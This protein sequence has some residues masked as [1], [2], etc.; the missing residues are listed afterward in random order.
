M[1]RRRRGKKNNTPLIAVLVAAVAIG[2]IV[3]LVSSFSG[4]DSGCGSREEDTERSGYCVT[5]RN[6]YDELVIVTGNTQNTPAPD[7]DFTQGEL[8]NI[9][10]GVFYSAERGS[11]PSVSIVSASG[12]NHTIDYKAKYKVAQNIIASNN[13]LKKLGKELNKAIKSSPLEPGADYLGGIIEASNL[14]SNTAKNPIIIVVGSGYNDSGALN[15]ASSE[16]LNS[17]LQNSDSITSILS[18]NRQTKEGALNGASVYWYNIGDVVSPQSSMNKYKEDT[19]GIYTLALDYLG[20]GR[21]SLNNYTGVTADAKSVPSEYSVQQVYVDELKIGDTFSVNENIGRFYPD[22]DVL[23]EPAE[24]KEKLTSFAKRF[25]PVSD[26]KLKLTGYIAFCVDDGQLGLS[27]AE[28]IKGILI[29]LGVP[30]DKIE[31]HG[32]RGSPPESPNE[33]Y[34]C[35]S[36]LPETERRTVQIEVVKG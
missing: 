2:A 17:Y 18:Q 19:R 9:L 6:D 3:Y 34:T 33:S 21:I 23:I 27:R 24:V 16:I 29:E 25:N 36:N 31:T 15:F 22:R 10:G 8:Y 26:T 12:D 35:Q 30:G 20:A 13:E 11:S 14:I 32:E 28:T 7:L 4:G 5:T 1:S